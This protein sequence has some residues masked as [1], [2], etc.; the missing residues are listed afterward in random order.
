M[1]IWTLFGTHDV[2]TQLW[3]SRDLDKQGNFTDAWI[4][5]VRIM[6]RNMLPVLLWRLWMCNQK[7]NCTHK[8]GWK[9]KFYSSS[10]AHILTPNHTRMRHMQRQVVY[11]SRPLMYCKVNTRIPHQ[12][13]G[14]S[15]LEYPFKKI[16][17][18]NTTHRYTCVPSRG[19]HR[20][21]RWP[22]H[23]TTTRTPMFPADDCLQNLV[24]GICTQP[25][26][27]CATV[28]SFFL[29]PKTD[30]HNYSDWCMTSC[31]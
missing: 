22:G 30:L 19:G 26:L 15:I 5:H 8:V 16:R 23:T 28:A 18:K 9:Y 25:R 27:L 1:F 6:M 2:P 7:N 29:Q 24:L 17:T 14:M 13:Q 10:Q 12:W 11:V 4:V 31:M 3:V 21:G 20:G